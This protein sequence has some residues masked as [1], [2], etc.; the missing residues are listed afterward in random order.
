MRKSLLFPTPRIRWRGEFY[1]GGGAPLPFPL[2]RGYIF[3]P[4]RMTNNLHIQQVQLMR[5]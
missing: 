1:R 4:G 5:F 2:A 3:R